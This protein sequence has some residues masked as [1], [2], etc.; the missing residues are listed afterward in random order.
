MSVPE[1]EAATKLMIAVMDKVKPEAIWGA[2]GMRQDEH[3]NFEAVW[4]RIKKA[5]TAA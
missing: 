5:V 3:A 2:S 1:L 4:E